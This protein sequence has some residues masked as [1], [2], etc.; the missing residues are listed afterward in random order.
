[1]HEPEDGGH[2]LV[3]ESAGVHLKACVGSQQRLD[4]L[5]EGKDPSDLIGVLAV[6]IGRPGGQ[7]RNQHL[8]GRVSS[9]TSP[10]PPA[11]TAHR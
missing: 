9:T 3:E 7:P 8:G 1:L 6:G 10:P 4:R 5:L 2:D 11:A